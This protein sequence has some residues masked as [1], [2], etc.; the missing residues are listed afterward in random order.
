MAKINPNPNCATCANYNVVHIDGYYGSLVGDHDMCIRKIKSKSVGNL[1]PLSPYYTDEQCIDGFIQGDGECSHYV[2]D[3]V[4]AQYQ[5]DIQEEFNLGC[6][7]LE[8]YLLGDL[9]A[10]RRY[11]EGEP[12]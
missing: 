12:L 8:A 10:M 1:V 3:P 11:K 4:T 9:D 6:K 5:K 7:Y 2:E